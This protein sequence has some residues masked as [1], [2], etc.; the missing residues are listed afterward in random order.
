M[1]DVSKMFGLSVCPFDT[2]CLCTA[3]VCIGSRCGLF[4]CS[5]AVEV[6]EEAL[7]GYSHETT[8]SYDGKGILYVLADI[9]MNTEQTQEEKI[10]EI[11]AIIAGL[12]GYVNAEQGV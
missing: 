7:L 2:S 12:Q 4:S 1:D 3:D 11:M 10:L 6:E 5:S 8:Y 9:I